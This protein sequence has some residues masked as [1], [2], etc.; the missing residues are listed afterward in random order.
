MHATRQPG[1]TLVQSHGQPGQFVVYDDDNPVTPQPGG[2]QR[3]PFLLPFANWAL[4]SRPLARSDIAPDELFPSLRWVREDKVVDLLIPTGQRVARDERLPGQMGARMD[5]LPAADCLSALGLELDLRDGPAV[6]SKRLARLFSPYRYWDFFDAADVTIIHDPAL[7]RRLWDGCGLVSRRFLQ[8]FRQR[9][10]AHVPDRFQK[11][12]ARE[13]QRAQR[14]E[15][16]LLH[17]G[18]QEKGDVLVSDRL[19][20]DADFLFPAGSSKRQVRL[21]DGRTF[22]GFSQVRHARAPIQLDV[23]SLINHYPFFGPERL[24]AWLRADNQAFLA[25]LQ[26]GRLDELLGGLLR[27]DEKADLDSL[28]RWW[29]GSYFAGGGQALWFG[30]IVQALG[31]QR[32]SRLD[33]QLGGKQ[34]FPLPGGR[35]Y[36]FPAAVGERQVSPGEMELS[37]AEATAYVN[38]DDWLRTIVPVL[39]GCDGDDAIWLF[40]F[41]DEGHDDIDPQSGEIIHPRR[42]LVWRSPNLDGE[43]VLLRPTAQSDDLGSWPELDSRQLSPRIDRA[44][45]HYGRLEPGPDA[46]PLPSDADLAALR[47]RACLLGLPGS[48]TLDRAALQTALS[49]PI[50]VYRV[51]WMN[52]ALA[53]A[54]E[55]RGALGMFVNLLMVAKAVEGRVPADQPARLEQVIDGLVKEGLDLRPVKAWCQSEAARL[56]QHYAIPAWL[57]PRLAGLTRVPLRASQD[58]WFD[59]LMA[60]AQAELAACQ[61]EL[62]TLAR[63]CRPPLEL[64]E[65]GRAWADAA[66]E[67]LHAYRRRLALPGARPD[68][69]G[70]AQA[71]QQVLDSWPAHVQPQL[72]A[73][74]ITR[75]YAGGLE[76]PSAD[77]I[78]WQSL[79]AL[80]TPLGRGAGGE[81]SLAQRTLVALRALGILG[82]PVWTHVGAVLYYHDAPPSLTA[83]PLQLNGCWFNWL[84]ATQPATPPVMG[85]V[86]KATAQWAKRQMASLAGRWV[87]QTLTAATRDGRLVLLT[88]RANLLGYV[89]QGQEA[90]LTGAQVQVVYCAATRDGNLRLL[91]TPV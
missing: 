13:L 65:H 31:R 41:T 27:V 34:R 68:Y 55:N 56:A 14:L 2:G 63:A 44:D 21:S 11:G 29:L 75:L 33:H 16:T 25:Q 82:E 76:H 19:P 42:L 12:Y 32:L 45:I 53:R 28:E 6:L 3:Y 7:N 57:A 5:G 54:A 9:C 52:Q 80:P 22:V 18:G 64:V 67:V 51:S 71:A 1:E 60:G 38:D 17:A 36:L 59:R 8:R 50:T 10:L 83:I 77:D 61:A 26:D 85:A 40:P 39:G 69:V 62:D 66:G 84:R 30:G 88:A 4:R 23:Q 24:A 70:A 90:W 47:R 91:V 15:I 20:G 74:L 78:L 89:K 86:P 87:G 58:H 49:Q 79:P 46:L 35:A 37:L 72:V 81:G 43:Y 48:Q 73:G